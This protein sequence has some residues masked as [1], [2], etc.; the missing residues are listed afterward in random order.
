M[1][2]EEKQHG[3]L[4]GVICRSNGEVFVPGGSR[5]PHGHWTKGFRI[6]RGYLGVHINGRHCYVHRLIAETFLPN[7]E[8]KPEV[9]HIDGDPTNNN[10]ENLRWVTRSENMGNRAKVCRDKMAYLHKALTF[11]D[12]KLHWLSPYAYEKLK[13]FKPSQRI[14]KR[15]TKEEA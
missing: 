13:P 12:G 5:G 6:F 9:D 1:K 3:T 14:W 4:K 2:T 15:K 11:A 8:N 7:P 10:V